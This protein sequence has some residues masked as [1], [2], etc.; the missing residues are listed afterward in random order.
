MGGD[1]QEEIAV[2]PSVD[3][4]VFR[5]LP[6]REA[7]QYEGAGIVTDLLRAIFSLVPDELNSLK[8]FEPPFGDTDRGKNGLQRH[9]AVEGSGGW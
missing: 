4:L 3:E 8:L 2:A 7:A 6:Q 1:F 5:W 9:K